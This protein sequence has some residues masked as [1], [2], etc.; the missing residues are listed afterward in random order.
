MPGEFI[1]NVQ[2]EEGYTFDD[3]L[4]LP[5]ESRVLPRDVLLETRFSRG[6]TL[7][8]PL[9]SAAMDTVTESATAITMAQH[10]GI[11]IIHKNM[12][13]K[14]QAEEVSRVKK[15][16]SYIITDPVTMP[17]DRRLKEAMALMRKHNI[18]GLPIVNKGKLVGILTNRDMRFEDDLD[19]PVS[20]VMTRS[21][22]VTARENVTIE[23]AKRLLHRHRIEK[24][25]VV[26]GHGELRGVITV[27]DIEKTVKFPLATKDRL[28]KLMVGAALGI[29]NDREER[30]EALVKAG[31]DCLVVDTAHGHSKGVIDFV[32]GL[33]KRYGSIDIVAGNVA[34]ERGARALIDTGVDAVKVGVGPGSICTTRIVAGIGVPQVSAIMNTYSAAKPADVPLIADG[35]IK[36]SGDITKAIAAGADTVMIGNLFAGTDESPGDFVFFGGRTYKTYRGMGS[37]EA[38]KA[39]SKDRYAQEYLED[40]TK[41][42]PEGIEGR[43]PYKGSLSSV[44]YQLLGG[45]RAGMGYVGAKDIGE[46]KVKAKFVR[47][48]PAGLKESHVHDVSVTKE[49]PNYRL[50]F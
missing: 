41:F 21:N 30:A 3:L 43:V 45:L 28:G 1:D 17:P 15:Y 14:R 19:K 29:S 26:N 10:G 24:L 27:K 42:V 50:E 35:G 38:M 11:G 46:L 6:I 20:K 32:G 2:I 18:S 12:T 37:I 8:I 31:V 47:I 34:T 36:F 44:I 48:T 25:L 7:H 9:V 16:E 49:A 23:E 39:G 13:V 40:E 33:K 4:I 22:L 5:A